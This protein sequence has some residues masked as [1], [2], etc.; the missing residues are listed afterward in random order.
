HLSTDVGEH[1]VPVVQLHSE[2]RVRQGLDDAALNLDCAFLSHVLHVS[3][4]PLWTRW[5]MSLLLCAAMPQRGTGTRVPRQRPTLPASCGYSKWR[6]SRFTTPASR[7]GGRRQAGPHSPVPLPS[8]PRPAAPI[9]HPPR[10]RIPHPLRT[11]LPR[12]L[13]T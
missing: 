3:R 12:P 1:L 8:S 13:R 9:P 5:L 7:P 11:P 6:W 4:A 2:H 10:T